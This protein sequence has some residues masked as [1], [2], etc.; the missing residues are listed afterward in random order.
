MLLKMDWEASVQCTVSGILILT[1]PSLVRVSWFVGAVTVV[2]L[3]LRLEPSPI[4]VGA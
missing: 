2:G 1:S 3:V 4:H